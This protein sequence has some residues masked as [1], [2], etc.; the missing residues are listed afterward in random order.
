MGVENRERS[1]EELD[2]YNLSQLFLIRYQIKAGLIKT[3]EDYIKNGTAQLFEMVADLHATCPE[4]DWREVR[5]E[6]EKIMRETRTSIIK[7][8]DDNS[9][10]E[11]ETKVA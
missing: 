9:I 5:L 3:V 1:S 10:K 6:A 4:T 2:L 7:N 11:V 8:Q